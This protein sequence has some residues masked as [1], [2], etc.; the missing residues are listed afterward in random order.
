MI[1][2]VEF[3]NGLFVKLTNYVVNFIKNSIYRGTE[4]SELFEYL[5]KINPLRYRP[6]ILQGKYNIM[7][8]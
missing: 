7:R 2:K 1:L 4:S 8:N 5:S 6:N 3:D